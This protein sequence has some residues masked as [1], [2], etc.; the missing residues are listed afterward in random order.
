MKLLPDAIS[1]FES[2]IKDNFVYIDKTEF[3]KKYEDTGARVSLFLRPRRFGKTMFTEILRYYYDKA[4]TAVAD[5]LFKGTWIAEHPT[6]FK[7]SYGVLKFDFSGVRNIDSIE[8]TMDFFMAQ[9]IM[10]ICDFYNRY[11]ESVIYELS[12][13]NEKVVLNE[14]RMFYGDRTVFNSPAKII[15]HFL[16]DYGS[17]WNS[18]RLMVIIDEYDNFTNDILSRN[19][20]MFADIARKEGEIGAFYNVLRNF[21]QRKIVERI[22]VTGVLPVT[23]DTAVSG[24]VSSKLSQ[25]PVLNSLAGFTD[26]E[27]LELVRESVDLERCPFS[28]EQLRDV[29]KARYDGYRFSSVG[30]DTVYNPTLCISFVNSVIYRDYQDIPELDISSANDIDYQKLTGYLNLINEKDRKTIINAIIHRRLLPVVFPGAVKIS[31][32]HD[33]LD[34]NQGAAILYHLGFFTL[35]S[36]AEIREENQNSARNHLKVPNEYFRLLFSRYYFQNRK[37]PWSV[38]EG[39]YDFRS[40]AVRNDLTVLKKFLREIARAFV[41]TDNASQ[42]EAQ[43]GLAVYTALALN[44]GTAFRLIREYAVKHDGKYVMTDTPDYDDDSQDECGDEGEDFLSVSTRT[45]RADLV[46]FNVTGKGPSYIF[47]FKYVR[48]TSSKDETKEKMRADLREQA[49]KQLDFYV[50]DDDLRVTPDLHRYVLMYT[51][52]EFFMQEVG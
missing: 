24:F 46:A 51:Y 38:F 10:G 21:N 32:R 44:T 7:N 34:R 49:R 41:N 8:D 22:F 23:M 50:T 15:T 5:D 1:D 3:I 45:G 26:D 17:R 29:M 31:S 47:E 11:P 12:K 33:V 13:N 43:I 25:I 16:S 39:G 4:L 9:V 20:G 30:S 42:C 18:L 14:V 2:I 37:I 28:P 36:D 19:P 48:D 52:G 6:E 27:V 35:A 40:I